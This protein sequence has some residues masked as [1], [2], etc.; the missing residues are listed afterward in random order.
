[1]KRPWNRTDQPVYSIASRFGNQSNMHIISYVSAISM[2]PKLYACA[3]YKNT[4]T[5]ELLKASGT[6]V[7]QLLS[8]TQERLVPVLGKRS[9]YD[10]DKINWLNQ[11]NLLTEWNGYF[12]LA[13]ALAWIQLEFIQEI[14]PGGDHI[15]MIGKVV[16]WKNQQEGKPLALDQLRERGLIRG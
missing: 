11:R 13:D 6:C 14:D 5:L 3:V 12:V 10:F 15:L 16:R 4:F 1:M 8:C 2:E 7:L 9:G